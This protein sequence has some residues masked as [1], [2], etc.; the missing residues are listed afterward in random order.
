MQ[1]QP[2]LMCLV[3]RGLRG[4]R[5]ECFLPYAPDE[6]PMLDGLERLQIKVEVFMSVGT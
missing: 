1:T 2:Q 3:R 5:R 6:K 4:G